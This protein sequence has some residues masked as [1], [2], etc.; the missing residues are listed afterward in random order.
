M[1]KT[2][3]TGIAAVALAAATI[4]APTKADANPVWLVPAIIAAAG[5][6]VVGG[7]IAS[8]RAYAYEPAGNVYV[9]PRTPARC[10]MV[11]ERTAAGMRRVEVCD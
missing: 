3:T 10:H 2:L 7:A 5:G 6:L 9:E 1:V 8:N 11:R 4:S